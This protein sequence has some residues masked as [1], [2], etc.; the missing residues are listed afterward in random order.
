AFVDLYLDLAKGQQVLNTDEIIA[1]Y[2]LGS[3]A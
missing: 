2:R 3:N 1:R